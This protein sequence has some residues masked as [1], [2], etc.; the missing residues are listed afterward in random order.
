[1]NKLM[2]HSFLIEYIKSYCKNEG[3]THTSIPSLKFYM[4]SEQSQF[5][6]I[7]YEPSLCIALQGEKAIGFG[8]NLFG[9][10][11]SLYLLSCT[12]IPANVKINQASKEVPFISLAISFTES[13]FIF[14][15]IS[16]IF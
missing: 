8:E 4:T 2:Y 1:M 15:L 6:S 9:Y 10:S 13:L 7:I 11:P 12:N 3:I 14:K 16:E 5:R